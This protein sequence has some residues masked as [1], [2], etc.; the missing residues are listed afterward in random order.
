MGLTEQTQDACM[1]KAI[2][3][4]D[5]DPEFRGLVRPFL[6]ESGFSVTDAE[7]G[8]QSTAALNSR[9]FDLV[10]VDGRLPDTD[11]KDLIASWRPGISTPIVFVSSAGTD[12]D[13]FSR[14]VNDLGVML[15]VQKPLLPLVFVHQIE[16]V[17]REAPS[18]KRSKSTKLSGMLIKLR[19]EYNKE[20]P[21]LMG[22]L[23]QSVEIA[24]FNKGEQQ[25]VRQAAMQAHRFGG[26]A[27]SYGHVELGTILFDIEKKLNEVHGLVG[28]EDALWIELENRLI[29]ARSYCNDEHLSQDPSGQATK[30]GRDDANSA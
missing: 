4:V 12:G 23:S 28:Q 26:T 6:E 1:K 2:L 21:R 20:I 30:D 25:F 29:A 15:V 14:L 18:S 27:G 16:A 7:T 8:T 17:L 11:G 13:T 10:I 5:D 9:T 19:A 3:L 22:E 24:R